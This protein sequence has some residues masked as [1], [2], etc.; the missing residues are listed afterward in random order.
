MNKKGKTRENKYIPPKGKPSGSGKEEGLGMRPTLDSED[1]EKDLERDKEIT[2]K[3]TSGVDE[4]AANVHLRHSNRN[5]QKHRDTHKEKQNEESNKADKSK[6]DTQKEEFTDTKPEEL[7]GVLNKSIFSDLASYQSDLCVSA[8]IPTHRAGGEVNEHQDSI[9]FKNV[10]QQAMQTLLEK[11]YD[12]VTVNRILKPAYDLLRDE[13]FWLNLQKG[14]AVFMADGFFKFIKVPFSLH[15]EIYINN[16]FNVVPLVP[17]MS[18]EEKFYLL[19]ISKKH[20]KFYKADAFE[21]EELIIPEL[22]FGMSD[23]VHF[24][25]KDDQNLFRTGGHGST[26]GANFHGIGAGE[27]DEKTHIAMY[28]DE[29]DEVLMK[30]VLATEKA[31]LMIAAVDYLVPIYKSVAKYK[32][33]AEDA[34]TGNHDHDDVHKLYNTARERMARYFHEGMKKALQHFYNNSA[35]ELT[36]TIPEDVIPAAYYSRISQL[37]VDRDEHIWGTFDEAENNLEVHTSRM[38]GDECL[39]NKA[40]IK[41]IL[42]GGEVFLLSRSQMPDNSKMAAMMRY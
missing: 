12:E 16:S 5:R 29:V 9:L 36:S 1:L 22:P 31:P 14:I 2:E 11:K 15:E 13:A 8:F 27:P 18:N 19:V 7:P 35:T 10:L 42:N 4:L 41:T 28:F 30:Y 20:V 25:E 17:A 39:L 38:D 24:E 6:N 26:G 33:I 23:V 21:M 34:I 37:F 3:Y 40:V 32:H